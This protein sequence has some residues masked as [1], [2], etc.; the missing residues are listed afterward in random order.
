MKQLFLITLLL[1]AIGEVNAHSGGHHHQDN[2]ADKT[3]INKDGSLAATGAF[4]TAKGNTVFIE[5]VNGV[6]EIPL[7][8]LNREDQQFVMSKIL[9]AHLINSVHKANTD[10]LK[11]ESTQ[12]FVSSLIGLFSCMLILAFLIRKRSQ[13][14][15]PIIHFAW[16]GIITLPLLTS[17]SNKN[18]D[19]T[20]SSDT[21]NKTNT[22]D[23][24]VL[25]LAF[26]P[27]KDKISTHWDDEYFY[28][29]SSGIP[30]HQMMVGITA[31]IAQV[32]TPQNYYGD[33]AW[34]IP[35]FTEYSDDPVTIAD[36]LRR[37]AV[38][39][40]S[41]G[42]P[43]FNPVNAS[44]LVSK[45]LGELDQFGGHSGRGDDYHYHI[46]PLHLEATSGT[47][48]IAFALDGYPIYGSKE[49]DGSTMEDLDDFHGH[50]D[51]DGNFHYHG[52]DTYPF[53]FAKMR[54]KVTLS[55]SAPETQIEPQPVPHA[56]RGDPHGINSDNLI[57]TN[58]VEN[59]AGNGYTL[60][61]TSNDLEG[62][63][64]YSWDENDFFTFVFHDIDGTTTTETFQRN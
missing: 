46:A 18:D 60:Y 4:L 22:A 53:M 8:Q 3:W 49:P 41:N 30:A 19:P 17:C 13:F 12:T 36:D 54:G 26:A 52:T 39:L 7:N 14:K 27:Y 31:W 25:D 6:V 58:L 44:G 24:E 34:K 43:I 37:G 59:E 20:T 42:I 2:S 55:G 32:P 50:T 15:F 62:S 11:A 38:A 5:Q 9:E 57:I 10:T 40:A 23:P 35:L 64:E 33:D 16:F 48:P 29:E 28:V 21:V 47:Q 56:F 51:T 63:V 45:D 61:Y 1:L